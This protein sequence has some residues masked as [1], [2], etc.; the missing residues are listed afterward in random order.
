MLIEN[1]LRHDSIIAS[2]RL[3]VEFCNTIHV[4]ADM[5]S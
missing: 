1:L 4:I 3:A 5:N 2:Q